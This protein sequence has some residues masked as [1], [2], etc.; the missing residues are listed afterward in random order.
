M[1]YQKR[2]S[3]DSDELAQYEQFLRRELPSAVRRELEQAVE[4]QFIPLEEKLK[5]QLVEIVRDLQIQLFQAYSRCRGAEARPTT[6]C[7]RA[8]PKTSTSESPNPSLTTDPDFQPPAMTETPSVTSDLLC[9]ETTIENQ[10]APFE[11]PA[12]LEDISAYDFDAILFHFNDFNELADSTYGSMFAEPPNLE[13]GFEDY[14]DYS[15]LFNDDNGEGPS[16]A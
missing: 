13:K 12:L 4:R 5:S 2:K 10:L 9:E 7:T 15:D 3:S 14:L 11:A 8:G 6:N 16:R 1:V